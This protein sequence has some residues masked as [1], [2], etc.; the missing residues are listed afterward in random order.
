[1]GLG[2]QKQRPY[3]LLET[4]KIVKKKLY[5]WHIWFIESVVGNFTKIIAENMAIEKPQ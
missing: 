5:L 4:L 2:A 3:K 1:M